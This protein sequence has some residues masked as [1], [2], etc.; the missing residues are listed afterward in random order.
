MN[1]ASLI[2]EFTAEALEHIVTA[3]EDVL[4]LEEGSSDKETVNRLFRAL[5][6]IKGGAACVN[7]DEIK[8]FAHVM[9]SLAGK[10]RD[11]TLSVTPQITQAMLEG[12]DKLKTGILSG[13]GQIDDAELILE[14]LHGLAQLNSV[15]NVTCSETPKISATAIF[16]LGKLDTS[17]AREQGLHVFELTLDAVQECKRSSCTPAQL[18]ATL[19]S[20]GTVLASKPETS[21]FTDDS[22]ALTLCSF[23]IATMIDDSDVLFPGLQIEPISF[24][25]YTPEDIPVATLSSA[26]ASLP[27]EP[28]VEPLVAPSISSPAAALPAQNPSAAR[29]PEQSVR[30]PVEI[31]DKL[32]NLAGEL[33]VVRNRSMQVQA[34]GNAREISAVNQRLDVVTSDIQRTVM[35]TRMQPIGNVFGR[36]TRVVRDLGRSLGKE[37][38]LEISGSEVEF[39]KSIIDG[40]VEPLMHLVRNAVDHGIESPE[41]RKQSGKPAL[42]RIRLMAQHQAGMVNIQVQ[43]DGKGIDAE[44]ICDA[45]VEK[46]LMTRSQVENLSVREALALIFLPGFSTAKQITEISGRGVGMDVVKASLQKLG[47]IVEIQSVVG[48]GSSISISLPL[49]LA[50]IPAIILAVGNQCFAVPQ[51]SVIEVVWLHGDEVFQSIQQIDASEVYW[52]RG[53]MLPLIRLSKVLKIEPTCLDPETGLEFPDR[54]AQASDRRQN[55]VERNDSERSGVR[56][57]RVSLDNS[58]YIIV[59]RIGS[60]SFGLCVERIVD[61]EEIVVKPLHDRL[62]LSKVYAGVTV[63]GDG[64]TSFIL[65]VSELAHTGGIRCEKAESRSVKA[66]SNQDEMQK[67][68]VFTNGSER[69]A[70]PLCLLMRVDEISCGEIQ[71]A[72]GR[73]YLRFRDALIPLVRIEQALPGISS[74]YQSDYIYAIIPKIGQPVGIAASSI[75]EIAEVDSNTLTHCTDHAAIIGSQIVNGFATTLLDLC[76]L[77]NLVEP[78][79]M[80]TLDQAGDA[81]IRVVLAEDS[82]LYSAL[83]ASYLRGMGMDVQTGINGKE[84]LEII[85]LGG[86]DC[87][88][89]DIEMPVMDGFDLARQ[90]KSSEV[91]REIPLVGISAMDEKLMRP[92]ALAAGFDEF[93]SKNNL[94][95]L[96]ETILALLAQTARRVGDAR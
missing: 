61:T 84:V 38:E 22:P 47:G 96:G 87:V 33:V 4:A 91:W 28:M 21:A 73:E 7:F 83:L 40:I 8:K 29:S 19:N 78:G 26:G 93:R 92:R 58:L 60:D 44:K 94:P 66:I 39:D 46:G 79:W 69:F 53:K 57:R 42:G 17:E 5:H 16:D 50:I 76:T 72:V 59:L 90:L 75:I 3:E 67:M 65:D 11:G 24:I 48:Q 37:M 56:D 51:V 6:T 32:M 20:I 74:H 82:L 77:V 34:S 63:L 49:T 64:T 62:K 27:P 36:F 89:S 54:R 10:L 25:H 1:L 85:K 30:I 88:V 41:E 18:L 68:L 81:K 80:A 71:M 9:E 95:L 23:I 35:R 13:K 45:V 31:A 55:E 70:I 2:K 43:D 86:V 14:Q 52:L 12:V 15:A